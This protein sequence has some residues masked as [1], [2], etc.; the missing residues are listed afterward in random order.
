[1]PADLPTVMQSAPRGGSLP[2]TARSRRPT[3]AVPSHPRA[4]M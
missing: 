3:T 2:T 1:L 4:R